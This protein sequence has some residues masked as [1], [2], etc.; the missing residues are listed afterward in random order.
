MK[1]TP[2]KAAE[3]EENL[4]AREG[5]KA[6]RP[7][8]ERLAEIYINRKPPLVRDL[9]AEIDALN[10]DLAQAQA[11]SDRYRGRLD[12]VLVERDQARSDLLRKQRP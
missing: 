11:E 7:T 10:D 3:A 12:E 5:K 2:R 4:M 8:R 9:F 6:M 1:D